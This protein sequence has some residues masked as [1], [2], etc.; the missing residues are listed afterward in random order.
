MID[1]ALNWLKQGIAIIPIGYRSKR[2]NTRFLTNGEWKQ[3]QNTLPCRSDFVA[4]FHSPFTNIA[5]VCGWQNLLIVDFDNLRGYELW[6]QMYG[7]NGYADTYTVKTGRGYHLYYFCEDFP[8]HT[9]KWF[10]GEIKASGYCL[11]PPS[12]HPSGAKYV[13]IN[14]NAPIMDIGSIDELFPKG[15][16]IKAPARSTPTRPVNYKVDL[17]NQSFSLCDDINQRVRIT[18]FF[19]SMRKSGDGWFTVQCPLH[20]DGR[21][22]SGWID[23]N[24]N[25]FG[26]HACQNGSMSVIDF[27]MKLNNLDVNQTIQELSAR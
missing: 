9:L 24:R 14:S 10:G 16:L 20:D 11:I 25:R 18:S 4:W 27:H 3:Y 23:D 26:C 21:H 8:P 12:I 15:L 13:A 19:S 7:V 17:F 1:T 5:V 22:L 2:P 6:M